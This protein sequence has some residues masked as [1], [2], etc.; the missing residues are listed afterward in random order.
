M[1]REPKIPVNLADDILGGLSSCNELA[2]VVPLIGQAYK[3]DSSI[4]ATALL[5][6]SMVRPSWE[7]VYEFKNYCRLILLALEKNMQSKAPI[8]RIYI[9]S[10]F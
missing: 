7:H 3:E 8:S 5:S 1:V 6:Y 10:I 4:V 2:V 9:R